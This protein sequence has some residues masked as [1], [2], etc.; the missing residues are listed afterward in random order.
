MIFAAG[1]GTRLGELGRDTPKALIEIAGQTMLERTA[2]A[3]VAA[4]ADRI[5]VNVHHHSERIERFLAGR[6]LGAEI[7]LSVEPER[8]LETG[9]GLLQ[10]RRL[11]RGD[12]P[13][14]LHNVDVITDSDLGAM[15]AAH[16]QR[17]AL[18]TLAVNERE[19]RRYLL[20]DDAG[21]C[22]REDHRLGLRLESRPPRGAVLTLAFAGIHVCSPELLDRITEGGAFPIM[23]VYLRLAG[24]GHVI[25]PWL[26]SGLW[27]EIGN[28]ERLAAA[29]AAL[30]RAGA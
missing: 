7:V 29:R 3:L 30:E 18:A 1:L 28:A 10:A 11:F 13:I 8:P 5:V 21:L 4:G 6:D 2:R 24:E 15:V 23:D 26:H 16:R 12:R 20:F 19:T 14:L 9:G 17:G 27:L 22:G 25:A